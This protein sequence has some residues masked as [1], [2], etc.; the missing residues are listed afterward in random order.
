MYFFKGRRQKAVYRPILRQKALHQKL[1]IHLQIW[2]SSVT[3]I[4]QLV[5]VTSFSAGVR[6]S[7]T[8]WLL[9]LTVTAFWRDF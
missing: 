5:T 4:G 9:S 2:I 3:L 7:I 8:F 1:K 6:W